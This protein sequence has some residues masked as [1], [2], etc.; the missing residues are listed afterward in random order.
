MVSQGSPGHSRPPTPGAKHPFFQ[1]QR[2]A[3]AFWHLNPMS[4]CLERDGLAWSGSAL[5]DQGTTSPRGPTFWISSVL[6]FGSLSHPRCRLCGRCTENDPDWPIILPP[7][8]K[9]RFDSIPFRI[10]MDAAASST[11]RFINKKRVT[12]FR[13]M[14]GVKNKVW[15]GGGADRRRMSDVGVPGMSPFLLYSQPCVGLTFL[16]GV[17]TGYGQGHQKR[18][19]RPT[20]ERPTGSFAFRMRLGFRC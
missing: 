18:G 2:S 16:D 13:E 7:I 19:R 5:C 20:R 17:A 11:S 9:F 14:E 12:V 4:W 3:R 6:E 15:G 1:K 10:E 8:G